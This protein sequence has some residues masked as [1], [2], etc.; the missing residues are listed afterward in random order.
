MRRCEKTGHTRV[1]YA[2]GKTDC[3]QCRDAH[4]KRY[5]SVPGFYRRKY[6]L[7]K[8]KPGFRERTSRRIRLWKYGV[9]L[10]DTDCEICEKKKA[11]IVDHDHTTGQTRGFLCYR[12]NIWLGIL[13]EKQWFLQRSKD[14]LEKKNDLQ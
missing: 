11:T 10:P 9:D 2:S 12:C 13:E 6:L 3:R 14:Y 8:S 5:A 7:E 4:R 1:I